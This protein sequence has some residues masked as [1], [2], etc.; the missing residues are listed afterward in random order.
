MRHA[1]CTTHTGVLCTAVTALLSA[2][3]AV[4]GPQLPAHVLRLGTQGVPHLGCFF[5]TA[6][7]GTHCQVQANALSLTPP[8]PYNTPAYAQPRLMPCACL[9]MWRSAGPD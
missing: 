2:P 7:T 5:G 1:E 8:S 6:G 4:R 9:M 3:E